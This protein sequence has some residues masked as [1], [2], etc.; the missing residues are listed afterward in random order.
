MNIF[1]FIESNTGTTRII[2]PFVTMWILLSYN[3]TIK[4]ETYEYKVCIT[5]IITII[6]FIIVIFCM[7]PQCGWG[8]CERPGKVEV[9][10]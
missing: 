8:G 9:E 2:D 4:H 7:P 5:F 1:P 10:D 6:I 3:I